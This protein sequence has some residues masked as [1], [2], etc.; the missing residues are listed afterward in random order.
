MNS[1]LT[2]E[3]WNEWYNMVY[4]YFYRRVNSRVEA[5]ELTSETLADFFMKDDLVENQKSYI[6]GIARNKLLKYIQ[7]KT[8]LN[9]QKVDIDIYDENNEFEVSGD[10]YSSHYLAQVEDLKRCVERQLKDIDVEI[11]DMC[12][13]CEFSSERAAKELNMNSSN[14]RKRLSRAVHKLRD[15]CK[16]IWNSCTN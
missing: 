7:S 13:S 9:Q 12:I 8:R 1:S 10:Y 6:F 15:K 4:G 16:Q 14:I 5:D 3:A 11:V 2:Q